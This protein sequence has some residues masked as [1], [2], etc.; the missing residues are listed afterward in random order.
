MIRL[1]GINLPD[2][3]HI[4]HA[5]QKIYGIGKSKAAK[6][7][8]TASIAFDKKINDLTE[9]Q[10]SKIRTLLQD[11]VLEGDL[12]REIRLNRKRLIEI[13]SYRGKRYTAHLPA[14]GQRTRCNARTCKGPRRTVA[15]KKKALAKK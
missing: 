10:I 1:V 5:L 7:L 14:N 15:N 6:I 4:L 11:E 12:K 3:C 9:D 13:N 8:Q 2:N